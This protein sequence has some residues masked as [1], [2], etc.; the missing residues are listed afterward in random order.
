MNLTWLKNLASKL[1]R[2]KD[3]VF[4]YPVEKQAAYMA[5]FPEPKDE[6]ERSYFQ[7][8][9]QM[10]MYGA[11]YH[12]LLN[13]AALPFSLFLLFQY[14]R[15]RLEPK[16]KRECI[17]IRNDLPENI[18]P[19]SLRE[20]YPDFLSITETGNC[21]RKEDVAF[22]KQ[23]FKRY[24]FSWLFWMKNIIKTSQFSA[25]VCCYDPEVIITRDEFSLTSSAMT[26]FCRDMGIRRINV[27]HG[28]KLFYMRDSFLAFDEFFV[29]CKEYVDLFCSM[30]A[31]KGQFVIEIPPSLQ[32]QKDDGVDKIY[33]FTYYLGVEPPEQM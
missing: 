11:F 4:S 22:L 31:E 18:L 33:D 12:G 1:E 19:N 8:C 16:E 23:I 20:R 21:L 7:Y 2:S 15:I 6:L 27:L 25:V 17:F 29:W 3:S 28:E 30:R 9:C 24:P 26:R 10:K 14:R 13:L 32:I 5:H